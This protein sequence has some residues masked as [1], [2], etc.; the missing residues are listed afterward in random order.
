[1]RAVLRWCISLLLWGL[2]LSGEICS[3]S[4]RDY[5]ILEDFFSGTNGPNWKLL[6]D[7]NPWIFPSL[8]SAP[9]GEKAWVGLNCSSECII[10]QIVLES[11]NLEGKLLYFFVV[12][13]YSNVLLKRLST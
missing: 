6:P 2:S 3:I 8:L 9:C 13:V 1:M 10:F 7:D 12:S 5:S 11:M 4:Q